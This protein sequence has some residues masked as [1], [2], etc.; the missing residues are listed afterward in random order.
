M[1]LNF[2]I[3]WMKSVFM[4]ERSQ[5]GRTDA[6]LASWRVPL[7]HR[8]NRFCIKSTKTQMGNLY[9]IPMYSFV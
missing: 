5:E 7:G 2:T 6:T 4:S 8:Q 3:V 1:K 9:G